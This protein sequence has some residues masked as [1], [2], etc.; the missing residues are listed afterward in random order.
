MVN[1]YTDK[2]K[3]KEA[4]VRLIATPWAKNLQPIEE[5]E[6]WK[7]FVLE[8]LKNLRNADKS[9]WHHRIVARVSGPFEPD[10]TYSG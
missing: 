4:S 6:S 7:P 3:P 9:N 5:L 2:L 1:P 10:F 8:V